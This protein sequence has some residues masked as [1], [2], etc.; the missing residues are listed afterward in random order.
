MLLT[1]SATPSSQLKYQLKAE[2]IIIH[3]TAG[4]RPD[5]SQQ[6]DTPGQALR[7]RQEKGSKVA[8]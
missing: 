6:L 7:D 5:I 1:K 2:S 3:L 4:L 8:R